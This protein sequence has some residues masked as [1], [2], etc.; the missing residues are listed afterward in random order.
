MSV[1]APNGEGSVLKRVGAILNL[2]SESNPS[3]GINDVDAVLGV[4]AATAY[5]YLADLFEI[6]MLSKVSGRYMPG[7]KILELE[8]LIR[9]FDPILGV[10]KDLMADLSASSGCHVLLARMYGES[11]V[12]IY[13]VRGEGMPELNFVTG[14][15]M[16]LFRG[17]QARVV[18]A[19]LNRR[20]LK[21]IYEL[22]SDNPDRDAIGADWETFN[23]TLNKTRRRGY[24][25]SRNELDDDVTGIAA[26]VFDEKGDVIG[27]L[28]FA[29]S[30]SNPPWPGETA[31]A[32]VTVNTA[33]SIT[34][35]IAVA[36]TANGA[37]DE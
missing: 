11:L 28:V 12:E 37:N 3:I 4:S 29:F 7:P 1:V 25:I 16:P 18:L 19:F 6:G 22:E 17:S 9:K 15:K 13:Y 34:E 30:S 26:P 20:K 5:R 2:F 35:R 8:Y 32:E 14:R 23:E 33:K 10:S 31:I 24:Y 27:S 21:R 36:M